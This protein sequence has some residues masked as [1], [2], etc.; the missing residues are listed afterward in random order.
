MVTTCA[1]N[2]PDL[3]NY[4]QQPLE[5]DE[6]IPISQD[7]FDFLSRHP[8][9]LDLPE[10]GFSAEEVATLFRVSTDDRA[11]LIEALFVATI[12]SAPP[13]SGTEDRFH[14]TWDDN[15]SKVLT[16]IMPDSDSVRNSNRNASRALKRPDY[17]F[18]IKKHCLVRGEEKGS[19]PTANPREE[20]VDKLKWI[21]DPL[22]YILGLL[23]ILLSLKALLCIF[24]RISR[25]CHGCPI[26]CNH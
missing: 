21:Y 16:L 20:L 22:P 12:E 15:I 19:E 17:G 6:K 10:H 5:D 11:K 7:T 23:W 25:N 24:Y 13:T 18:L 26:C 2:L 1:L 9:E 8:P 4:L 14:S 3:I